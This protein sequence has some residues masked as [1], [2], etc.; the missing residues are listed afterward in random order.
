M[1]A[2]TP[3]LEQPPTQI[4]T[5]EELLAMGEIGRCELVEGNIVM[6]SPTGGP[7]GS[8]EANIGHELMAFTRPRK[9]GRVRVGEVGIYTRR[10]PDTVRGAA[11]LYISNERLARVKSSGYMDVAPELI[12]EVMSPDDSW[13]KVT[14]KLEEYFQVGVRV[15]I[16]A[17]PE[18]GRLFV[19]RA[20]TQV[21]VLNSSDTLT[22]EDVLPGFS[23]PVSA[24]FEGA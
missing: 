11:V 14:K 23:V 12:V 1:I 19:Y 10:S 7:H 4:I 20:L 13:S 3:I 5:G 15:V 8:I 21:Q 17:D 9:L 6:L 16:V 2:E 18:D 22:I 24:S